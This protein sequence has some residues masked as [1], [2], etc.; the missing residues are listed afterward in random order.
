MLEAC[1]QHGNQ[2]LGT[3]PWSK[4]RVKESQNSNKFA[5]FHISMYAV[6]DKYDAPRIRAQATHHMKTL[7]IRV[8]DLLKDQGASPQAIEAFG[9]RGILDKV[10]DITGHRTL[11]D[12]LRKAILDVIMGHTATRPLGTTPPGTFLPEV[13]KAAN[14]IP[15]FGRDMFLRVMGPITSSATPVSLDL[16]EAVTCP[17]CSGKWGKPF[18][19]TRVRCIQCGVINT[20]K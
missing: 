16:V 18:A 13:L 4:E 9:L 14:G 5:L 6:A 12:P 15:D 8:L 1:Y 11:N 17:N 19:Y 7:L 10:Y 2:Y 3:P 20:W